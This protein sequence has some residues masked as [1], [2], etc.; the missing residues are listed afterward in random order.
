MEQLFKSDYTYPVRNLSFL[1]RVYT[2]DLPQFSQIDEE[3]FE[4]LCLTACDLL[5]RQVK[6]CPDENKWYFENLCK[7]YKTGEDIIKAHICR[8][9]PD[10]DFFNFLKEIKAI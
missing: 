3:E 5:I 7:G 6:E 9:N 4:Y 8:N 10:D 2:S 1:R